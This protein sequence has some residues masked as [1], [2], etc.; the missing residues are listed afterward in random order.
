MKAIVICL[1]SFTIFTTQAQ[2]IK[3]TAIPKQA[4]HILKKAMNEAGVTSVYITSANRTSKEQVRIM[5]DNLQI[6]TVEHEKNLYGNEGDA[7]IDVYVASKAA[8]KSKDQIQAD[9]LTELE[10]QLPA[11]IDNKRLMH[12]GREKEYIVFDMDIEKVEPAGKLEDFKKKLRDYESDGAIHRF[13]DP[14]NGEKKALHV[15]VKK[16]G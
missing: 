15:E 1:L 14:T 16:E 3:G 4:G 6:N 7:V 5:Y 8:G 11:A 2:E 10:K 9:M 13:L 12:V